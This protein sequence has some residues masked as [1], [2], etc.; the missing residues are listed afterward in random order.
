MYDLCNLQNAYKILSI[1][2]LDLLLLYKI[3]FLIIII[4]EL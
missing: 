1:F 3:I 2:L 4:C